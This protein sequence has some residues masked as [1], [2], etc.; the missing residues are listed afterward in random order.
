MYGIPQLTLNTI[1]TMSFFTIFLL[2]TAQYSLAAVP[3]DL[4]VILT[5]PQTMCEAVP[6]SVCEGVDKAQ[7]AVRSLLRLMY[8][9]IGGS[10]VLFLVIFFFVILPIAFFF[11]VVLKYETQSRE[12]KDQVSLSPLS[13]ICTVVSQES[14]I[15]LNCQAPPSAM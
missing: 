8:V 12:V 1:I 9:G 4:S 14:A 6:P 11:E 13:P 10:V 2:F 7:K 5:I 3:T 15:P